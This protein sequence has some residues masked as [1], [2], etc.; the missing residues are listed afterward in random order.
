LT[1]PFLL[2]ALQPV[3]ALR[4]LR[5]VRLLRIYPLVRRLRALQKAVVQA[6]DAAAGLHG[7]DAGAAYSR[8]LT[9]ALDRAV[10][11]LRRQAAASSARETLER[12][13]G[14]EWVHL[15]GDL[16]E[17]SLVD[18]RC[19]FASA[20]H[21]Y[22]RALENAVLESLFEPLRATDVSL[23]ET[24]H[25]A[26]DRSVTELKKLRAGKATPELG[27]M[28]HCLKNVPRMA[29]SPGNGFVALLDRMLVDREAFCGHFPSRLLLYAENYRNAAAHVQLM[30][31]EKCV[32]ARAVLVEEPERLLHVL[33]ASLR[34][35]GSP[36]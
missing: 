6:R 24:G 20:V 29:A 35:T 9:P 28:A 5:L 12:S 3:R 7:D 8:V 22:S 36:A 34:H 26:T 10:G 17:Y 15:R 27:T 23:P 33:L 32:E 18:G 16:E 14:D 21:A 30:P 31:M 11:Q 13:F 4:L 19:D 1:P 25:R 2:S